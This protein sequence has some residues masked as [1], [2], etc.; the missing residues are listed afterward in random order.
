MKSGLDHAR[1]LLEK[2]GND[3]KAA[4]I[5]FDHGAP[6]D[7]IAFHLQQAAEKLLKSLLASRL[8]V[9]PKT[10]DLDVLFDLVPSELEG[11]LSFQERLIGW[12]SYAVDMRYDITGYPN[13][14]E[15]QRALQTAHDFHTAVLAVIPAESGPQ[16][17]AAK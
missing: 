6:T 5:G 4:E 8:I 11:V 10:H 1:I 14:E 15:M 13:K 9:Y 12:T 3:L 2:A 7:T 16:V 17:S